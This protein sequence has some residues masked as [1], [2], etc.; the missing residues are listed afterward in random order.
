[1]SSEPPIY[2]IENGYCYALLEEE[3]IGREKENLALA[4]RL[5]KERIA[6]L[7][8][9]LDLTD[10]DSDEYGDIQDDKNDL[11]FMVSDFEYRFEIL[12]NKPNI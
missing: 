6:K 9:K 7:S 10:E 8:Q 2:H 1:M 5:A 12:L 3:T 4:I 11:E